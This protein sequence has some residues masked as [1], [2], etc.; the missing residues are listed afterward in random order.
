MTIKHVFL[1]KNALERYISHKAV[2]LEL[3]SLFWYVSSK[4]LTNQS[5]LADTE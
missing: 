5:L 4:K 3:M 1:K 2:I